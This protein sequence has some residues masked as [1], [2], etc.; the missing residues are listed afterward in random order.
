MMQ[1]YG[2]VAELLTDES[3][4]ISQVEGIFFE[5]KTLGKIVDT[6]KDLY[7]N[8]MQIDQIYI[9]EKLGIELNYLSDILR[10]RP[11]FFD[12]DYAV[13]EIKEKYFQKKLKQ[14]MAEL[15]HTGFDSRRIIEE[16]E[17]TIQDLSEIQTSNIFEFNDIMMQFPNDLDKAIELYRNGKINGITSG[18]KN[19]DHF[20]GGYDKG[21]LVILAG[22]PAMGKSTYAINQMIKQ[23]EA[24]YPVMLFSWEMSEKEI[25]NKIISS[26]SKINSQKIKNGYINEQEK[27]KLISTAL[28]IEQLPIYITLQ[29]SYDPLFYRAEVRRNKR[30]YGIENFYFDHIG[31]TIDGYDPNKEIS[32]LSRSFKNIASDEDVVIYAVSQLSRA[33]EKRENKRPMLSDLRD[34]GSLE[35]DANKILFMYRDS[36]Y[37]KGDEELQENVPDKTEVLIE[38]NRNGAVGKAFLGFYLAYSSFFDIDINH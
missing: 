11:T 32:R 38:K 1:E 25:R 29:R 36:Y 19:V 30:K 26:Y 3:K 6:I 16:L 4:D 33:V 28:K 10:Q 2:I 21:D 27:K 7:A 34:S 31:L 9:S 35:Q 15:E 37:K 8:N 12:Y 20:T 23:A 5:N 18:F 14:K 22:R 17:H 13:N 24:G